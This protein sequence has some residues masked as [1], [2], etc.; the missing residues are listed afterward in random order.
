MI[1]PAIA[2]SMYFEDGGEKP[3]RPVAD[4]IVVAVDD[5][6]CCVVMV[7]YGT[8]QTF[9]KYS[10]PGVVNVSHSRH[11]RFHFYDIM[12]NTKN[13]ITIL[14]DVITFLRRNI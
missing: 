2:P 8:I 6:I 13:K 14:A 9:V 10:E 1:S 4:A 11:R 3:E 7:H 12:Y 5:I